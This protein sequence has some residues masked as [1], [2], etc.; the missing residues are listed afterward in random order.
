[1]MCSA[2]ALPYLALVLVGLLMLLVSFYFFPPIG[3]LHIFRLLGPY[4]R[5][6]HILEDLLAELHWYELVE[7]LSYLTTNFSLGLNIPLILIE[8]L[9]A[10]LATIT[11]PGWAE[12]NAANGVGGLLGIALSPAK[13]FGKFCLVVVGVRILISGD[14][15]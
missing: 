4:G 1:M 2:S 10:G 12:A 6:G 13:G 15:N 14:H 11:E 9:G 8:S 7:H 5:Q 3:Q